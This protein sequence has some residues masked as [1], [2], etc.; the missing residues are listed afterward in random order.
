[1][2]AAV[3]H[4]HPGL[5]AVTA[6]PPDSGGRREFSSGLLI[7]PAL[8]LTSRHGVVFEDGGV[9]VQ[10]VTGPRGGLELTDPVPCTIVWQGDGGLDAALL[11]LDPGDGW[12]PPAGFV[13]RDLRW[14]EPIG[15][16][17]VDVTVVGMPGFAADSTGFRTETETARGTVDP[18]TYTGSDRYAADLR[19]GWPQQWSDW[20][21]LSGSALT[22]GDQGFV[23]GVI[24]WSDKPFAGRRLAAV[25]MRALLAEEGFGAVIGRHLGAVPQLEPGCGG[26]SGLVRRGAGRGRHSGGQEGRQVGRGSAPALRGDRPD[27]ELPGAADAHLC[28]AARACVRQPAT[29][30]AEVLDR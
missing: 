30:S 10:L 27:R 20:Q 2:V 19:T 11:E 22:C 26:A 15:T 9:E 28:L 3:D 7:A 14:G 24:G 4:A 5:V 1:V 21:G 12:Q 13:P 23:I 29:V 17:P 18:G 8:V 6:G 16:R 25:P